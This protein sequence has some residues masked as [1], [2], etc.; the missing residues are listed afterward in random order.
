MVSELFNFVE[1]NF[2]KVEEL[3]YH[4]PSGPIRPVILHGNP[5]RYPL[6]GCL[7]RKGLAHWAGREW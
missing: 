2:H 6:L 5:T 7:L 4:N 1:V 3:R